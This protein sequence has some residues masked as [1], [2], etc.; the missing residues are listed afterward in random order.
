[1]TIGAT[2]VKILGGKQNYLFKIGG[3]YLNQSGI[4]LGAKPPSYSCANAVD[5]DE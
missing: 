1:L 2:R 5:S 3:L 4:F